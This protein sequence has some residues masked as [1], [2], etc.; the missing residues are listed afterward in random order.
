VCIEREFGKIAD[1]GDPSP[2]GVHGL[3]LSYTDFFWPTHDGLRLY[4]RVYEGPSVGASTVVCLHGLTRNSRDF[5][6]LSPH[7]QTRI[8]KTINPQ[9]IFKTSSDC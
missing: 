3:S 5:E 4:S 2:L 1:G 9:S 6:D 8:P 7:L